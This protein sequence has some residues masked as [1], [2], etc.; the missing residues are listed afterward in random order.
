MYR[1]HVYLKC[2]LSGAT[3]VMKVHGRDQCFDMAKLTNPELVY[4]AFDPEDEGF[5]GW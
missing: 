2:I 4:D 3:S 5:T 1:R